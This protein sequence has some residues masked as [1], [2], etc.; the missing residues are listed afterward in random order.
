MALT[1]TK[2]TFSIEQNGYGWTESQYLTDVLGSDPTPIE[3]K[4][5]RLLIKRRACS[6]KQ[7]LFKFIRI[8]DLSQ[9]RVGETYPSTESGPGNLSED[10]DAPDTAAL[11]RRYNALGSR[12]S[13]WF[14]RGIWD[15]A[16]T[17]GGDFNP[18]SA[19]RT[20]A[21]QP[22]LAQLVT[23]GWCWLGKDLASPLPSPIATIT[24]NASGQLV[25]TT[26]NA[27]FPALALPLPPWG[28]RAQIAISQ[29]LG[30]TTANGAWVVTV[31]SATQCTTVKQILINPYAAGT[32]KLT[33][34]V[35]SL[36]AVS[37]SIAQR[38]VER[39]VGKVLFRSRGRSKVRRLTW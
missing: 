4:A 37:T 29:V 12:T 16:V 17:A 26:A 38:I 2:V 18:S 6:G 5:K 14:M 39:K 11:I 7:T 13:A 34:N 35:K 22:Y 21:L 23:D 28:Y 32:G 24:A 9:R 1:G 25:V 10:S 3:Q 8:Q 36:I 27:V 20:T 19:W 15:S 33:Y 31:Q 30:A